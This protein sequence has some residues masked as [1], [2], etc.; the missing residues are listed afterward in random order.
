MCDDHCYFDY[1]KCNNYCTLFKDD[2]EECRKK[3]KKFDKKYSEK[4]FKRRY[5]DEDSSVSTL[6]QPSRKYNYFISYS[7]PN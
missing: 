2:D 3:K 6:G 1:C 5:K 4:E 7:P